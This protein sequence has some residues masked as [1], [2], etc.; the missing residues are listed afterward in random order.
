VPEALLCSL[1][2]GVGLAAA[3][4][5]RAS[6][7]IVGNDVHERWDDQLWQKWQSWDKPA[8]ALQMRYQVYTIVALPDAA[9]NQTT[10]WVPSNVFP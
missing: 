10:R 4:E 7:L 8:T 9:E 6:R 5:A 2:L 1:N 3:G